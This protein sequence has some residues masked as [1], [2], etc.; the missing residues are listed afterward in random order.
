MKEEPEKRIGREIPQTY[1]QEQ[2]DDIF[3]R[4][5]DMIEMV[6]RNQTDN[7]FIGDYESIETIAMDCAVERALDMV[8]VSLKEIRRGYE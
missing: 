5:K 6:L 8:K 4:L 2:V 7:G 1:T 3:N